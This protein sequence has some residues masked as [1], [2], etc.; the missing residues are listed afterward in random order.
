M[1]YTFDGVNKLIIL[2]PGTTD[3]SVQDMY[4]RWVDWY[5]SNAN[6][7]PAMRSVGGD[8][9][10]LVKNL[11]LTFFMINSLIILLSPKGLCHS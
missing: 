7:Y 4:S 1:G 11:G 5:E 6:F 2:T 10:S 3:F 9:I 8:A